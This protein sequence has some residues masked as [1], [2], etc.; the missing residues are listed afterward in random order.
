ME[1]NII[2]NLYEKESDRNLVNFDELYDEYDINDEDTFIDEYFAHKLNYS[3][4][5]N[6]NELKKIIDFYNTYNN[7]EIK[8][9]KKRKDDII[10]AIINY[11]LDIRNEAIV[12]KRKKLWFYI[13]E[14]KADKYLSKYIIFN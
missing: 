10:D 7:N 13:K 3:S 4:N 14:I 6:V 2:Y 12:N 11:E 5:Y 8:L 9:I 1:E